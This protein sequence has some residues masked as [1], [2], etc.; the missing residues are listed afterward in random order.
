MPKATL[1]FDLPQEQEDHQAAVDGWKYKAALNA[2]DQFLRNEIKH[3][4]HGG[5]AK[6]TFQIVRDTLRETMDNYQLG[7]LL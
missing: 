2:L 6:N 1:E 5:A 3:G 7:E 4:D